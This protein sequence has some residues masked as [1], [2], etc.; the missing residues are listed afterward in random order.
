MRVVVSGAAGFMG[1]HLIERLAAEHEVY[2]LARQPLDTPGVR[3]IVHDLTQPLAQAGLPRAIDAVIHLAQSR[4]YRA[5]PERAHDIYNVNVHSTFALLEYARAAGA[6]RFC[7]ASTGS[8]YKGGEQPVTESDP[9]VPSGFYAASKIAAEQ[10]VNAY[11][12]IMQTTVWRFF[13]V[14]GLRQSST[15][16]IPR[17]VQAVCSGSAVTLQ[18]EEGI[19]INPTHI[20]DAVEAMA[21]SLLLDGSYTINVAG[22]EVVS[23]RTIANIIAQHLHRDPVFVVQTDAKPSHLI[24]DIALMKARLFTPSVT[25]EKGVLKL[26]E[27]TLKSQ[28]CGVS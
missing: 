26:C 11:S 15:M 23:L 5:F 7:L 4:H 16:L 3:W 27:E 18:G 13:F 21:R 20:S 2:A 28:N 19:C 14:Y 17:L 12:G 25:F 1:S 10:L 24:A 22:A 9:V 6:R 8:V